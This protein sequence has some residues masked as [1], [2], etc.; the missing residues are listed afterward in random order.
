M[1]P[2][3][4]SIKLAM[5]RARNR[6]ALLALLATTAL[7][8]ACHDATEPAPGWL[9]AS[10]RG[11]SGTGLSQIA[12]HGTVWFSVGRYWGARTSLSFE[13]R[14]QGIGGSE[15]QGIILFS[16]PSGRPAPGR[17]D[18]AP[19]VA[20]DSGPSGFT[21]FYYHEAGG[22]SDSYT[23]LT[24]YVIISESSEDRVEGE[25]K[26]TGVLFCRESTETGAGGPCYALNPTTPGAPQVEVTGWFA[27]IPNPGSL[28]APP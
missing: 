24:G 1:R 14:S 6:A 7:S 17:Y 9:V 18:L 23:A 8:G 5:R 21:A 26:F 25:F 28:D 4:K 11:G 15:G 10:V 13:L 3:R 20:A 19:L 2:M 16:S 27:A 22:V 12:Y